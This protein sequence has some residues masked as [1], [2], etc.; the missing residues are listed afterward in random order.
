MGLGGNSEVYDTEMAGL[1]MAATATCKLAKCK[2]DANHIFLF[3]DNTA[4]INSIFN[5]GP[6]Q[7]Y[8]IKTHHHLTKFLDAHPDNKVTIAWCPSHKNIRGN[9]CAD[10]LAKEARN[11]AWESLTPHTLAQA[12]QS[13]KAAANT[14]WCKEWR[15]TPKLGGYATA[16]SIPPSTSP[17]KTF[18]KTPREVFGHLIQCRTNHGYTGEYQRRFLPQEDP[19]CPCGEEFQSREHIIVHCTLHEH[20]RKKLRKVSRDVWLPTILGIKKGITALTTFL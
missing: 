7:I 16:N 6:A 20:S 15:E 12:R 1:M 5:P 14:M 10:K 8:A 4:A 11:R 19:S 9:E 13:A 18:R 17:T 3:A 2:N